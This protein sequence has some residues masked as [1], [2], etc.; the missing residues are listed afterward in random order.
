M[1][2]LHTVD[3]TAI[4]KDLS[5]LKSTIRKLILNEKRP[6]DKIRINIAE[7]DSIINPGDHSDHR[8]SSHLFQE[9][10]EELENVELVLYEEYSSNQKPKN[11]FEQDYLISAG[12]WGAT[13]SGL[14]D[15]GHYSTWDDGHNS[16]IG[17]QYFRVLI[18]D[19]D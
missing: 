5:D 18:P 3:S 13:A 7:T 12:T 14:S 11:V 17:R 9:I 15:F 4:Y 1:K 10:A 19:K 6:N 16:W 8:Y 2:H